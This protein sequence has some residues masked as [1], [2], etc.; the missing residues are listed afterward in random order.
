[1]IYRLDDR[2]MAVSVEAV[3]ETVRIGR[4]TE[5]FR[6]A[7]VAPVLGGVRQYHVAPDGRFLMLKDVAAQNPGDALPPQ[8]V[9]V[10][11]WFE[12]LRER[13]GN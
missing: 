10:Q 11:N 12:E 2:M 9:L 13:V 5:L 4:P 8:V 1:L 7:Y 6:G 3:G